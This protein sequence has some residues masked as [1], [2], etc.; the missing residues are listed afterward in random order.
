MLTA[1]RFSSK[2]SPERI[3]I[4]DLSLEMLF[5]CL[6][7]FNFLKVLQTGIF[8]THRRDSM[9]LSFQPFLFFIE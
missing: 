2:R 7:F 9:T 6:P 4:L 5:L 1:S 8:Q 3:F